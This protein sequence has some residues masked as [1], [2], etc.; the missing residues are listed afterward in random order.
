MIQFIASTELPF[1]FKDE[2]RENAIISWRN[3]NEA[4]KKGETL[5][6]L[7]KLKVQ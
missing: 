7:Q 5:R 2:D 1:W 4:A 6:E 3:R